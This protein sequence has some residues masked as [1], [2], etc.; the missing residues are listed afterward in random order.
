MGTT[1]KGDGEVD[2]IVFHL[3]K[4]RGRVLLKKRR[5][6]EAIPELNAALK[7]LDQ[8]AWKEEM[9]ERDAS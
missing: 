9:N 4:R 6:D 3:R 8:M 5:A 1:L 7:M 2:L